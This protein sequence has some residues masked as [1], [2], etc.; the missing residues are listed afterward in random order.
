[1]EL[2]VRWRSSTS[3]SYTAAKK[4]SAYGHTQNRG[5]FPKTRAPQLFQLGIRAAQNTTDVIHCAI[6][7][8]SC[9]EN[10]WRLPTD[11]PVHGTCSLRRTTVGLFLPSWF[12]SVLTRFLVYWRPSFETLRYWTK[13][14]AT[15]LDA[16]EF[17]NLGS[18]EKRTRK[19]Y[20]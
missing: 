14:H 13:I 8:V 18:L 15:L 16:D 17:S 1:M 10:E 12:Q 6:G 3:S 19:W 11:I 9:H 7:S 2:D 20:L 5:S 4:G